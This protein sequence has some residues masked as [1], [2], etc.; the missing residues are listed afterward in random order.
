MNNLSVIDGLRQ[1]ANFLEHFEE[2]ENPLPLLTDNL[3]IFVF[4][5]NLKEFARAVAMLGSCT[6][7]WGDRDLVICKRFSGLSLKLYISKILLGYTK[8]VKW[9]CPNTSILD[10]ISN[11]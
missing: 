6:Q 4:F 8:T 2:D 7:E 3:S 1:M 11:E 5:Y 9:S 10:L